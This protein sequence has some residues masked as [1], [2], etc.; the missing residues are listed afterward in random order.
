MVWGLVNEQ[1]RNKSTLGTSGGRFNSFIFS[2]NF[3][4]CRICV[5]YAL[6][7]MT[8]TEALRAIEEE[9]S[10]G[11]LTKEKD[12]HFSELLDKIAR[13]MVACSEA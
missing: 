5:D 7:K 3:I 2:G 12:E 8:F 11:P 1:R 4:M 10:F 13:D 6:E 9:V